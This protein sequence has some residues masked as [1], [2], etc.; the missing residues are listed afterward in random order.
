MVWYPLWQ[1]HD[2][3]DNPGTID[4]DVWF[5]PLCPWTWLTARWVDEVARLRPIQVRWHL[6][7]LALLNDRPASQWGTSRVFTAARVEH[8]R[9]VLKPLYD[10]F[11]ARVH[12]DGREDLDEVLGECL[13]QVGLPTSLVQAADSELY[14]EPLR[15]EHREGMDKVGDEVGSPVIDV[16]GVAFFGPV[17][18]PTPRGEQALR[19]FDGVM[20]V[21]SIDGFFE[22]KRSRT[23]GPV[24]EP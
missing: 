15:I 4:L 20:A 17:V 7:S 22:L 3:A 8:G 11:S 16:G 19:L 10:A 1:T 2:V 9:D 12:H 5:D 14:D 24:F 23:R 18:S 21:A 6:L 13:A